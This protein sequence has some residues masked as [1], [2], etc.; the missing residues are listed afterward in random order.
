MHYDSGPPPSL[1]RPRRSQKGSSNNVV[2]TPVTPSS[3]QSPPYI[4]S[5][6]IATTSGTEVSNS[7]LTSLTGPFPI[8]LYPSSSPPTLLRPGLVAGTPTSNLFSASPSM[9][10]SQMHLLTPT[11]SLPLPPV[12]LPGRSNSSSVLNSFP[13]LH[14]GPSPSTD[15][16]GQSGNLS[17]ERL[18]PN[19][20]D[21]SVV[22]AR[23][24]NLYLPD[25]DLRSSPEFSYI[26][27]V[28]PMQVSMETDEVNRRIAPSPYTFASSSFPKSMATNMAHSGPS[29][30]VCTRL[31]SPRSD[32]LTFMPIHMY[33]IP[34]QRITYRHFPTIRISCQWVQVTR[35]EYSISL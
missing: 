20:G 3:T 27:P 33:T 16:Q 28:I 4:T 11:D 10:P 19:F 22:D 24:H 23:L 29:V 9:R 35:S 25:N 5:D 34:F 8:R 30:E 12:S 13:I 21:H 7:S 2:A 26:P 14:P 31:V 15:T 32:I 1:T 17:Y 6:A 18:H